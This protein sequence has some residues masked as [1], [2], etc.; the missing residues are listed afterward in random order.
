MTIY[1]SLPQQG[2]AAAVSADVL[3]AQRLALEQ[4]DGRAGRYRVRL[5]ALDASSPNDGRTD[6]SLVSENARRAVDDETTVAYL[7]ELATGMSAVSIPLLNEAGILGVSPL[8]GAMTLTTGS[9]AAT[10]SPD[11]FYPRLNEVGRTFARVVPSDRTQAEALLA[12]MRAEGVKRLAI[13]TDE[14]PS[15]RAL[16]T[17][18]RAL[19]RDADVA[20]V[21]REEIDVHAREHDEAVARIVEAQPDAVLDATGGRAGSARLWREL[22]RAGPA[23]LLFGPS[24]LVDASFL[25]ALGP[26]APVARIT[27]P[28]P[29]GRSPTTRRFERAFARR[30]QRA[31]T[32]EAVFGYESMRSVLAAIARASRATPDGRV[33]R[34]GVVEQYFRTQPRDSVLGPYAIDA[35]GDTSLRRWGGYVVDDGALRLV[36]RLGRA[37]ASRER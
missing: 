11:R 31:P 12:F 29:P 13:L 34:S 30:W 27:R 4:A 16:A 17:R 22:H 18:V 35:R 5:V 25:G 9:I 15:G 14:D 37:A 36:R 1:S 28:L 24:S 33:T 6:P 2:P 21:A 23:L 20:V 10:G 19:A 3:A 8:D 7:G 26:A 32:P